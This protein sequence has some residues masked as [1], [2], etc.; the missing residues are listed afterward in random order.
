MY[1][2]YRDGLKQSDTVHY[3]RGNLLPI[4]QCFIQTRWSKPQSASDPTPVPMLC[5]SQRFHALCWTHNPQQVSGFTDCYTL[6]C[7]QACSISHQS[8]AMR[9]TC[10]VTQARC[11]SIK[12]STSAAVTTGGS[13]P[14]WQRQQWAGL[15]YKL[16]CWAD[17]NR[18]WCTCPAAEGTMHHPH[19]KRS[20]TPY[21]ARTDV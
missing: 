19:V 2:S 16:L 5:R 18:K 11:S 8:L 12:L 17:L 14:H 13:C 15:V 1:M 9:H 3:T 20:E 7:V 6:A 10:S 4:F 21:Q